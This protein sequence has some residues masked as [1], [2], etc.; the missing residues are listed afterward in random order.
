MIGCMDKTELAQKLTEILVY[1]QFNS[2]IE[3]DTEHLTAE[4]MKLK[5][6]RASDYYLGR[7]PANPS[8]EQVLVVNKFHSIVNMQVDFIMRLLDV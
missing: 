1:T 2:W 4:D 6:K 3:P 5:N 8:V 7:L